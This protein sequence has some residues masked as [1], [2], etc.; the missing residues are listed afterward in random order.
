MLD[1]VGLFAH[2]APNTA[3]PLAWKY[4]SNSSDI[5][6]SAPASA[7]ITFAA[8]STAGVY[9]VRLFAGDQAVAGGE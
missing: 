2:D 3:A 1:W 6:P 4:L 7:T 5:P 8:P 9:D